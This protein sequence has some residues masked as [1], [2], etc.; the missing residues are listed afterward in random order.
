[1]NTITL[2]I[3]AGLIALFG[4][5][6][7]SGYV[8]A[9]RTI[10]NAPAVPAGVAPLSPGPRTG[11]PN[12]VFARWSDRRIAEYR[13]LLNLTRAS[14]IAVDATGSIYVTGYFQGAY[15]L[16]ASAPGSNVVTSAGEKDIFLVKYDANGNHR[17]GFALNDTGD[18]S[19]SLKEASVSLDA[20]G[21]IYL[22]G[23]FNGTMNF[24]PLGSVSNPA[25]AGGSDLF[26]ARYT[27]AGVVERAVRIGGTQNEVAPPAT[28][29]LGPEGNV[30][31]TGRFRGV[32]DWNPGV[33]LNTVTNLPLT[34]EEDIFRG[35]AGWRPEFPLGLCAAQRRRAGWWPSRCP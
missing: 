9:K 6:A 16:D 26:I 25:S 18:S 14:D 35:I 29:R 22:M 8:A 32:V 30:Y 31:L 7:G 21:R 12:R 19:N 13:Q 20:A 4:L 1:M 23:H 33:S 2:K 5:G 17:W 27:S 10:S 3:L 34:S 28:M 24:N 15:D 11:L